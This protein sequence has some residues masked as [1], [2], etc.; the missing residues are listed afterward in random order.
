MAPVK[1]WI[2]A[3]LAPEPQ[4]VMVRGVQGPFD[5]RFLDETNAEEALLQPETFRRAAGQQLGVATDGFLLH[6][7]PFGLARMDGQASA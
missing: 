3:N 7:P 4:D 1:A 6:L 5:V 2:E